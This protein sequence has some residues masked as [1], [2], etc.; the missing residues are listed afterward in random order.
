MIY[1]IVNSFMEGLEG[2]TDSQN[3][4]DKDRD[5]QTE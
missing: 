4:N 1:F 5:R 3:K 2:E